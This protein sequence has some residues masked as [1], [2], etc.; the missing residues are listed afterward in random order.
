MDKSYPRHVVE[1]PGD[2]RCPWLQIIALFE[3]ELNHSHHLEDNKLL[4]DM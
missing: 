3:S 1:T 4:S 2:S